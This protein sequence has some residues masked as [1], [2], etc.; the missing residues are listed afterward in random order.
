METNNNLITEVHICFGNSHYLLQSE[1]LFKIEQAGVFL[2]P[3]DFGQGFVS[4][5]RREQISLF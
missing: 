2:C 1:K 3:F 4:A 5:A